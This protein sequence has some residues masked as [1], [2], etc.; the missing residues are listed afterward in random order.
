[1][2]RSEKDRGFDKFMLQFAKGFAA[3]H[4]AAAEF[5]ANPEDEETIIKN[6]ALDEASKGD[7]Q[8]ATVLT[9]QV[10]D[11]IVVSKQPL[12]PI[13]TLWLATVLHGLVTEPS[14]LRR[15]FGEGRGAPSKGL[16][17]WFIAVDVYRRKLRTGASYESIW[18]DVADE[19]GVS[20]AKVKKDWMKWKR[21]VMDFISEKIKVQDKEVGV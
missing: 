13:D 17:S 18:A 4:D 7:A 5:A 2:E 8:F 12:D 15:I 20:A 19:K 11:K 1:V 14:H 3:L 16:E 21:E 9:S 6:I 10:L